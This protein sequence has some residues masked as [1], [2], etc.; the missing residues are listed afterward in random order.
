MARIF[1]FRSIS[2]IL[3]SPIPASRS[4]LHDPA[5]PQMNNIRY[6][7]TQLG[8]RLPILSPAAYGLPVPDRST[9]AIDRVCCE[10]STNA[11]VA[12]WPISTGTER[13]NRD[14]THGNGRILFS[15]LS[16]F[17]Q[18]LLAARNRIDRS[19]QTT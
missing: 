2:N 17:L 19:V 15:L 11:S 3:D 6:H 16:E 8:C 1:T 13:E 18:K 10:P 12:E 14:S 9:R 4:E 7:P 5:D